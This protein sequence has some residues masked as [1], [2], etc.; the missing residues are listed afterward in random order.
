MTRAV[1]RRREDARRSPFRVAGPRRPPVRSRPRR[2][3]R[4][5]WDG[6]GEWDGD[7]VHSGDRGSVR[8]RV[9]CAPFPLLRPSTLHCTRRRGAAEG[10]GAQQTE[11]GAADGKRRSGRPDARLPRIRGSSWREGLS[12]RITLGGGLLIV[13]TYC[14]GRP[15]IRLSALAPIPGPFWRE[16]S[17]EMHSRRTLPD[18]AARKMRRGT[19]AM[20]PPLLAGQAMDA[21]SRPEG[22]GRSWAA[23]PPMRLASCPPTSRETP[24]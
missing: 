12:M 18:R 8:A 16:R 13:E 10:E 20:T 11:K 4:G 19:P 21:L 3:G 17:D 23:A 9:C 1:G 15:C 24:Q 14:P 7:P 2:D 22:W 5:R 6:R